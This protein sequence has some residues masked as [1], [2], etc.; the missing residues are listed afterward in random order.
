MTKKDFLLWLLV[1]MQHPNDPT[2]DVFLG[3]ERLLQED[4]ISDEA[5]AGI[6]S[7]LAMVMHLTQEE[8]YKQKLQKWM[9]MIAQMQQS[10]SQE[11]QWVDNDLQDIL[12]TL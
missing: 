3:L 1:K 2:N 4:D 7:I 11:N 5:I 8:S 9:D 6:Q 10:E 12:N